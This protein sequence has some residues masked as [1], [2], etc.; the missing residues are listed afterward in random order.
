MAANAISRQVEVAE[1]DPDIGIVGCLCRDQRG[2]GFPKT[3]EIFDGREV[4]RGFLR[5][6][7]HA[8][9]GTEVLIRRSKLDEQPFYDATF[10][11]AADTDANLRICVNSKFGFVHE[12]LA[13]WRNPGV[14]T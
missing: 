10:Q 14:R 1:R 4:I 6:E 7:H 12:E 3:Q 9:H 13:M 8:L 2:E 11:G 5:H